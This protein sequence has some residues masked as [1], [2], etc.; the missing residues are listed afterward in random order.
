MAD[1][2]MTGVTGA[3]GQLFDPG[4]LM[5][6]LAGT[7]IATAARCGWR[8]LWLAGVSVFQQRARRFDADANRVA[9]ARTA[10]AIAREGPLCADVPLPPDRSLARMVDSFVRHG[11]LEAFHAV[12]RATRAEREIARA[13]VV[14]VFEYAG[15]LAPVFGLVG[16]LVGITQMVP[17]A[18][19][20]STN[21]LGA[22]ATAVLS[23][24]YGVLLAQLVCIP[25]A[26]RIE[27]A[28]ERE[29]AAR[30]QLAEWLDRHL[31]EDRPAP[32]PPARP[33]PLAPTH[34]RGVA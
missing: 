25:I 29:E 23:T 5:I 20:S 22:I 19:G 9:L 14:R 26:R 8:E 15:E 32:P 4:A 12:R 24:L 34:L 16:T 28:S 3:I 6:V 21:M 17:A 10:T 2:S 11:T 13:N 27:R 30:D 31:R 7:L 1:I 33:Q 18:H